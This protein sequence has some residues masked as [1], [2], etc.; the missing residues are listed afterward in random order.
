MYN[1]IHARPFDVMRIFRNDIDRTFEKF[2]ELP[3]IGERSL[4]VPDAD[5]KSSEN[6]WTISMALPGIDAN[7]VQVDFERGVLTVSGERICGSEDADGSGFSEIDYGKFE[8][9]FSVPDGVS[10]ENVSGRFHNG[11]L[12]L[13]LPMA[14]ASKP[15][16]IAITAGTA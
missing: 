1:L 6:G 10:A 2:L 16:K 4:W 15:R 9:R 5:V 3:S 13:T 14:E 7:D 12:E 8:R 11:M